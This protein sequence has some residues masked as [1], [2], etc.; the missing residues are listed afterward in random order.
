MYYPTMVMM[1]S[2]GN[3]LSEK[4]QITNIFRLMIIKLVVMQLLYGFT[5]M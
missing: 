3:A 4:K 1:L 5:H 2:S